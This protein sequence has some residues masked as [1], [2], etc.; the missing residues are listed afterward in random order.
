MP[1]HISFAMTPKQVLS[2]TKDVTR[3]Q[4]WLNAK[5]GDLLQPVLKGMGLKKGEKVTKLGGLI[6]ITKVTREPID[7]IKHGDCVREG[8]PELSP[9]GFVKMYCKANKC[10]P[11]NMCTRIEFEYVCKWCNGA[12]SDCGGTGVCGIPF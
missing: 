2:Q 10:N 7:N 5:V 3:R 11:G 8:F 6:R 4:G 9:R 12:I 1:R